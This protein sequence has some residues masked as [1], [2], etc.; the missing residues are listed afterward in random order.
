[1]L[2][3][4]P[5]L[6]AA[7]KLS[8]GVTD[9]EP[10]D[11]PPFR[12][13]QDQVQ[14]RLAPIPLA[15]SVER[16][17]ACHDGCWRSVMQCGRLLVLGTGADMRPRRAEAGS[18]GVLYRTGDGGRGK[19]GG[20]GGMREFSTQVESAHGALG[21]T[22]K[23]VWPASAAWAV[24][25]GG[26]KNCRGLGGGAEARRGAKVLLWVIPLPRR[27]RGCERGGGRST[28]GMMIVIV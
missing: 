11:Y 14:G 18:S 3:A 21:G 4:L 7:V 20:S 23:R 8:R 6:E 15:R 16:Q 10:L 1:M 5:E 24:Q 25:R 22:K 9:A 27:R 26:G 13:G 28:L 17:P 12:H 19:L 2:L